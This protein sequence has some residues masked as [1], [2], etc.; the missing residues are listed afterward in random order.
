MLVYIERTILLMLMLGFIFPD[1]MYFLCCLTISVLSYG[2]MYNVSKQFRADD[3]NEVWLHICI[4][5]GGNHCISHF[6]NLPASSKF[7]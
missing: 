3:A 7:P 4:K 5:F 1:S 2:S 6:C